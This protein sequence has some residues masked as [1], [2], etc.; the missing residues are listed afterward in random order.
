MF[1]LSQDIAHLET[2]CRDTQAVLVIIDPITAYLGNKSDGHSNTDVRRVL[3]PLAALAERCDVAVLAVTHDRKSGGA[4]GER[5]L[6]S[7]AFIAA[8]RAV[9][10]VTSETG[11][12]GKPM[13]K[14]IFTRIKGN[15]GP[16]PGGLAYE[17]EACRIGSESEPDGIATSRIKWHEGAIWKSADEIYREQAEQ[18]GT[19]KKHEAPCRNEAED[20]LRDFLAG[21]T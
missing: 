20:F 5:T 2:L 16:D 18:R 17:I 14:K 12:D 19:T 7:V 8:P 11:E 3:A 10:A 9:W 15:L 1:D 4:A 21:G 13:G 6:G